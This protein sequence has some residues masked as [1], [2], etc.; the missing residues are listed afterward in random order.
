ME[1]IVILAVSS[2]ACALGLRLIKPEHRHPIHPE[3]TVSFDTDGNAV[4][5]PKQ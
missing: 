5:T 2:L 1:F 4:F 3:V